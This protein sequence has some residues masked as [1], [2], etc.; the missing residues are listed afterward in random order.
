MI[1][2]SPEDW[3]VRGHDIAGR[4]N[5][6]DN[7]FDR[8][9]RPKI[10]RGVYV[11]TPPPAAA[12]VALEQLRKAR[13]KRHKSTHIVIVPKLFTNYWR[14]QFHKCCDFVVDI[15][16]HFKFW[17]SQLFEPLLMGFC[18]PYLNSFSYSISGTPKLCWMDRELR[19]VCKDDT[20][21]PGN[22]LSEL[23]QLS[24]SLPTMPKRLVRQLLHF[25]PRC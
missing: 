21:D 25:E 15:P 11:W 24:E 10:E 6:P 20:M 19:K 8:R 22:L 17:N 14:K 23:L 2:L 18:F 9:W 3:F 1:F 13:M 5:N 7:K 12:E 4:D 16:A